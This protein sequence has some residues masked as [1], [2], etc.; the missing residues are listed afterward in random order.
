MSWS[1]VRHDDDLPPDQLLRF[2]GQCDARDDLSL[3]KAEVHF[4]NTEKTSRQETGAD[5]QNQRQRNFG[6]RQQ[7]TQA[8]GAASGALQSASFE[9]LID[10]RPGSDERRE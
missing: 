3:F 7:T 9:G 2:I 4:R 5:K 6:S 8:V 1:E 10:V